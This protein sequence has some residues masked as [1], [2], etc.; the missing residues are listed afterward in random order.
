[1]ASSSNQL[2]L[3]FLLSQ[4][5]GRSHA[6]GPDQ[7]M[8]L[9]RE[10][11]EALTQRGADAEKAGLEILLA[12]W[13][14]HPIVQQLR[15]HPDHRASL[16]DCEF[17]LRE[18]WKELH[19]ETAVSSPLARH[20]SALKSL[21]D[22]G[23]LLTETSIH[24]IVE[25]D[26]SLWLDEKVV[27]QPRVPLSTIRHLRIKTRSGYQV[28]ASLEP[29]GNY[30]SDAVGELA[31]DL[32]IVWE[33]LDQLEEPFR[34]SKKDLLSFIL[35]QVGESEEMASEVQELYFRL[36]SRWGSWL[37][38]SAERVEWNGRSWA[39]IWPD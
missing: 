13:T 8:N 25:A 26:R 23:G 24:Q 19:G 28:P 3:Q 15:I 9:L 17:R 6:S 33:N 31:T 21:Q 39:L 37:R 1:M 35:D 5:Q 32:P 20:L 7:A 22:E 29:S 12:G 14:D 4:W 16:V 2:Y 10:L 38:I 18:T 30:E 11:T 36:V 34:S 27:V